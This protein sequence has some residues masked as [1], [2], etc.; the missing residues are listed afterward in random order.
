MAPGG[1]P[2][3]KGNIQIHPEQTSSGASVA[4]AGAGVFPSGAVLNGVTLNTLQVGSGFVFDP[5]TGDFLANLVG[6][7]LLGLAQTITV[8]GK[9]DTGLLKPDGSVICEGLATVDMGNGTV[10]SLVPFSVAAKARE[11]QLT[12][13]GTVLPVATL[14]EGGMTIH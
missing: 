4:G 8:E 6:T 12:I 3:T 11:V 13:F 10:L 1:Q 14:T 9:V 7:S 2:I 5:A